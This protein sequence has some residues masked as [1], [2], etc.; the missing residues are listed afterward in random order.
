MDKKCKEEHNYIKAQL[1]YSGILL[2]F[3]VTYDVKS[4]AEFF[5]QY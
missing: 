5:C 4:L 3:A 1:T 2:I